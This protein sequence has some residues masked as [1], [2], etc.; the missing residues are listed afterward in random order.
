[1]PTKNY[2]NILII[3]AS[4]AIAEETAREFIRQEKLPC[5][6]ALLARTKSKLDAVVADLSTR[7]ADVIVNEAFDF[8]D[9]SLHATFL[10]KA[11]RELGSFDL[12]LL[13]HGSL[14]DQDK[15]NQSVEFT[16]QELNTNLMS[17]ASFLT[18]IPQLMSKQRSGTIAILSSVAGDRGRSSLY[19][20]G[21]AKA[22]LISISQGLRQRLYA[23]GINVLLIK[24]G[25]IDTPMTVNLSRKLPFASTTVVAKDIY[26]AV[27]SGKDEIYTPWFWKYIMLI[28]KMIPECVFKRLS[29]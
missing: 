25:P 7:G 11:H 18:I 23:Q 2:Q 27:K 4:S 15:S 20:Y 13:A 24:P 3:G 28:L 9:F 10:E 1:M 17:F 6:F 26:N 19:T 29:I 16:L 8:N 12:V 22:A 21:A 5:R 14:T